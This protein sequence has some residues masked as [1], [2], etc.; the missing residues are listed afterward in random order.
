M[1]VDRHNS[2]IPILPHRTAPPSAEEIF[3]LE[4]KAKPSPIEVGLLQMQILWM[5]NRKSTHGYEIMETL[6]KIKS[7]KVAQGT[8]YPALKS[9]RK[10]GYIKGTKAADRIIYDI[11]PAGKKILNDSCLDFTR[12]FFGIFQDFVCHKCVGHD[13]GSEKK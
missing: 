6:N 5:L 1:S 11:T 4:K 12:T 10:H 8:L 2:I 9:L 3:G 7:T 13:H